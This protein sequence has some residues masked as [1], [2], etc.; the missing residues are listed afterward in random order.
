MA[1][2]FDMPFIEGV[3]WDDN[4]DGAHVTTLPHERCEGKKAA[5]AAARRLLVENAKRL[6]QT[7]TIEAALYCD[8]ELREDIN[9][10]VLY[11]VRYRL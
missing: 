5:A 4:H 6:D 9:T 7:R 3:R 1:V 2:A 10:P 11:K 8:L